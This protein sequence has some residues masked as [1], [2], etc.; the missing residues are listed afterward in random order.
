MD[1]A[2][3]ARAS[4]LQSAPSEATTATTSEAFEDFYAEHVDFV[5]RNV[6]QLIGF[7]ASADDV[8]QDV[9][10]VAMRRRHEFEGRSTVR[11][12]LYGILRRVAA[13]YRRAHSRRRVRD[14][15]DLEGIA[16]RDSGPHRKAEKA[17][18]LRLLYAMLDKLDDA[19]REVFILAEMEKMTLPQIAEALGVAL[20]TVQGRLRDARRELNIIARRHRAQTGEAP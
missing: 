20:T 5:W 3:T 14:S 9:F 17:D 15:V 8:V 4:C 11:S 12:W 10:L 19:K 18:A 13:D 6:R 2:S 7:D 1:A 16:T